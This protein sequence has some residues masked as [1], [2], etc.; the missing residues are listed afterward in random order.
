MAQQQPQGQQPQQQADPQ[1][2]QGLIAG[3]NHTLFAKNLS[4]QAMSVIPPDV[5][6][7]DKKFITE[8]VFKFCLL[9]GEALNKDAEITLDNAQASLIAQFIGEWTFHKSIDLIRSHIDPNLRESILQKVA[10]TVFEIAKQAVLKLMPQEQIIPL[11][12]HHVNTCFKEVM[13]ELEQKGVIDKKLA[14]DAL[15]QSNIDAMTKSEI[16]AEV[17]GATMSDNKIL[18]LASLAMLIKNFDQ[19]KIEAI[20]SKFNKPEA[21]VLNQYLQMPDL[22]NKIDSS[23]TKK[24]FEEMKFVLPEPKVLTTNR[25]FHKLTKIVNKAQADIEQISAIIRS[26]RPVVKNFAASVFD[27]KEVEIPP[28]VAAVVCDYI[29]RQLA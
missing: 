18:K 20:L 5:S 23:I 27:K 24:C 13:A 9:A 12:E 2:Q 8:V 10:F 11:V 25:F 17:P 26:E 22:E 3:F 28:R 15:S 21:E 7:E 16:E 14:D 6:E 4:E 1:A 19:P 29:E